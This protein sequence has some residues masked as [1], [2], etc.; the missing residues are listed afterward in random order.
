MKRKNCNSKKPAQQLVEFLLVA[1][2]LI[3][4]L[5]ILTEYAYALNINLT[6][7]QSLKTAT[8][9]IY[10]QIKPNMSD[11]DIL[12]LVQSELKNY[13]KANNVPVTSEN[14]LNVTSSESGST[15][16]FTATYTYTPAF[17]LPN[18]YFRFMPSK[19]NFTASAAVPSA[20]L[21]SNNYGTGYNS[22]TLDGIWA[23][24]AD[25]SSLDAFND[26][27]NGVMNSTISSSVKMLF[28]TKV[29]APLNVQSKYAIIFWN[30]NPYTSGTTSIDDVTYKIYYIFNSDDGYLYKCTSL[31][32]DNTGTT[33]NSFLNG[34]VYQNVIFL[35]DLDLPESTDLSPNQYYA[36]D[37]RIPSV[38]ITPT[39]TSE[40]ISST[41]VDGVLKRAL[42]LV[43]IG[44]S[45]NEGVG[46]Y[47]NLTTAG[48]KVYEVTAIGSGT[49]IVYQPGE[50]DI[51][52]LGGY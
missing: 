5:G 27:K 34:N 7:G 20:F 23:G 9:S 39:G 49:V 11:G 4:F 47:D 10:H 13:L 31:D 6:L 1:P 45:S 25:F 50:D 42:A 16:T 8:T 37:Q 24:N 2:F 38:W 12:T 43:R 22:K 3:I 51:S 40:K 48:A 36:L 14:N 33:F 30:G 26:S 28:L 17:T 32:C 21:Q 15:S 44:K 35:H 19:F 29:D 41:N 52:T 18:I 46:N